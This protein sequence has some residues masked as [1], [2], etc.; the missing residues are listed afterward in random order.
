MSLDERFKV[1]DN[2]IW[3]PSTGEVTKDK[4]L[5]LGFMSNVPKSHNATIDLIHKNGT[6]ELLL[7]EP[8]FGSDNRF[9]VRIDSL[10]KHSIDPMLEKIKIA[11]DP[12]E[13]EG[14]LRK[15]PRAFFWWS[16]LYLTISAA[17][18][19]IILLIEGRVDWRLITYA[20]IILSVG[21]LQTRNARR[22]AI[23]KFGPSIIKE[24]KTKRN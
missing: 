18:M 7:D 10:T 11:K 20:F 13:I 17:I 22:A 23:L 3:Q 24:S 5:K 1:G 19:G 8:T 14:I 15:S 16:L 2:V 12:S 21:W 4:R 9:I 6:A